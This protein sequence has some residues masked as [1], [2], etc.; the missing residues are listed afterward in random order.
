MARNDVSSLKKKRKNKNRSFDSIK[1]SFLKKK[2]GKGG[3]VENRGN[4]CFLLAIRE[5]TRG[6][7]FFLDLFLLLFFFFFLF[8]ISW[9]TTCTSGS[10]RERIGI[11]STSKFRPPRHV[12]QYFPSTSIRKFTISKRGGNEVKSEED[13]GISRSSLER[14]ITK[15]KLCRFNKRGLRE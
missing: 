10:H 7:E 6:R 13:E 8:P 9:R 2:K 11:E 4:L 3:Y 14:E 15:V 1:L 12:L 5:I